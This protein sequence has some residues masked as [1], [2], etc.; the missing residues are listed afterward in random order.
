MSLCVAI[1]IIG[2]KFSVAERQRR[3]DGEWQHLKGGEG[4]YK[5][6]VNHHCF[7]IDN[8]ARICR[9]RGAL[10]RYEMFRRKIWKGGINKGKVLAFAVDC[11]KCRVCPLHVC[12]TYM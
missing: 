7:T 10:L 5:E 4:W 8:T 11:G 12:T 6:M 2:H 1:P 9:N 3:A